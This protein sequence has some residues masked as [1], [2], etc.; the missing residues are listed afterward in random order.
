MHVFG[1]KMRVFSSMSLSSPNE[2]NNQDGQGKEQTFISD[3]GKL[4]VY[5]LSTVMR[6]INILAD[7]LNMAVGDGSRKS[8]SRRIATGQRTTRSRSRRS[9]GTWLRREREREHRVRRAQ[10]PG[11]V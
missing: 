5:D 11:Q 6:A 8:S 10:D 3:L 7:D 9:E 1:G 2:P 4:S